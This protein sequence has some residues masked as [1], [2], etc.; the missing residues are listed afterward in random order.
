[1]YGLVRWLDAK[2]TP[3][4]PARRRRYDRL[5]LYAIGPALAAFYLWRRLRAH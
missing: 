1:M 2:L 5:W 3:A 4:D